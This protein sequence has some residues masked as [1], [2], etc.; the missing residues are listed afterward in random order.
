MDPRGRSI[1]MGNSNSDAPCELPILLMAAGPYSFVL[2]FVF[3]VAA[4][5]VLNADVLIAIVDHVPVESASP[6]LLVGSR[7]LYRYTLLKLLK[8]ITIADHIRT[9]KLLQVLAA[10]SFRYGAVRTI[11]FSLSHFRSSRV[12][13]R[14]V[15]AIPQLRNLEQ[16]SISD[17]EEVLSVLPGLPSALSS[18]PSIRSLSADQAGLLFCDMLKTMKHNVTSLRMCF[19]LETDEET[20]YHH[21]EQDTYPDYHPVALLSNLSGSL[22]ELDLN[23]CHT[24]LHKTNK[25]N[26]LLS[27]THIYPK[28]R[29]L[30]IRDEGMTQN[31]DHLPRTLPY[32]R[33]F[34]HLTTLNVETKHQDDLDDGF[35]SQSQLDKHRAL[36]ISDQ[37]RSGRSWRHLSQFTGFL[38]DLYALAPLSSIPHIHIA[39]LVHRLV[40]LRMLSACLASAR[41]THLKLKGNHCLLNSASGPAG[42]LGCLADVLR[43]PGVEGLQSLVLTITL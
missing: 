37:T 27:F 5:P 4:F 42:V 33:A 41:P 19:I 9:R 16:V 18:L 25:D 20:M 2:C 14:L 22:E 15:E 1:A 7:V 3:D 23:S 35:Y 31:D 43:G 12:G 40:D 28:M 29:L 17:A 11:Y 39:S 26:S 6:L 38:A 8:T 21:L 24:S 13:R 36:N 10:G 30:R 34:P 32:I